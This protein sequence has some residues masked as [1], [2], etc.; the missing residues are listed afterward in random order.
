MTTPFQGQAEDTAVCYRHKSRPTAVR[1]SN[2]D[3]PIC[4]DCMRSTPVGFRCPECAPTSSFALADDLIVTKTIIFVNVVVFIVGLG[5]QMSDGGTLQAFGSDVT[6]EP[7]K[8]G[9]LVT[10]LV[11]QGEWWRIFTSGFLHSGF[12]HIALNMFFVWSFGGLLEP[13]LGRVRYLLLYVVGIIGGAVGAMLLSAPNVATV[14]AS[15]AGFSLLGAAL[16]MARLRGHSDLESNLL[17]I[18]VINFGFT[19]MASGI[20]VGGHLGGFVVGLVSGAVAYGPLARN[21][22]AIT[23]TLAAFGAVLFVAAI[24]VADARVQSAASLLGN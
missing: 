8:S 4:A 14:G 5:L 11:Q 3:R 24:L 1:C 17:M 20:S 19:F 10:F 16:V 7:M 12:L 21:K 23:A 2:C 9:A 13:A 15:G 18:A 6:R 22:P